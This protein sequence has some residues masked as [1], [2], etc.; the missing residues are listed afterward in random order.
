MTSKKKTFLAIGIAVFLIGLFILLNTYAFWRLKGEQSE[1]NLVVG[2][3]LSMEFIETPDPDHEG[4]TIGGFN[5]PK[6]WPISDEEGIATT[7]YTFKIKNNCAE[8]VNYQVVLESLKTPNENYFDYEYIKVMLD[9]N[10][11]NRYADLSQVDKDTTDQNP[12][13]ILETKQVFAGTLPGTDKD[14]ENVT[15]SE[16]THTIRIWVASDA[17]NDQIGKEF[18]SRIKVFAGQGVPEPDIALTPEECFTFD[19]STGTITGY[20]FDN[21]ICS[22]KTLVLPPTIGGVIVK[23][24]IWSDQVPTENDPFSWTSE[25]P[26]N[27]VAWSEESLNVW[28][29][30]DLSRAFGLE[31]IGDGTFQGYE[32]DYELILPN[33][34]KKIGWYAFNGYSG[35][36]QKLNIP[37]S[38]EFIGPQAFY[39]YWGDDLSLGSSVK[40]IGYE[41]FYNYKGTD[42]DLV[43]P[44]SV[45]TIGFE[46]FWQYDGPNLVLNEGLKTLEMGVFETY[47]GGEFTIPS[48]IRKIGMYAFNYYSFGFTGADAK[49]VNINMSQADFNNNSIVDLNNSWVYPGHRPILNYLVN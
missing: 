46:A 3:C 13:N 36:G 47:N 31:V 49:T 33:N 1:S 41:A 21:S 10:G 24:I 18:K 11:I 4:E 30:I 28:E 37:D 7:G 42:K 43:I 25:K 14:T 45:E 12:E 8:D 38:V 6:A 15:K 48:T 32:G 27:D 2:A 22:N 9:N 16:I 39:F 34:L 29:Y 20:D 19:S 40:E 44:S 23:S 17:E 5:I 35:Q 26:Y